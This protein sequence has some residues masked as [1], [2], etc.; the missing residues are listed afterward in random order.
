M[1][2]RKSKVDKALDGL[3]R[4][5][6]KAARRAAKRASK[7][8][9]KA[10]R[11]GARAIV[12]RMKV[13]P[14]RMLQDMRAAGWTPQQI[15]ARTGMSPR[16]QSN[17]LKGRSDGARYADALRQA[18]RSGRKRPPETIQPVTA[19]RIPG[20]GRVERTKRGTTITVR[21]DTNREW[22]AQAMKQAR[23]EIRVRYVDS[24]GKQ[25]KAETFSPRASERPQ[26][27]GK[28]RQRGKVTPATPA[29]IERRDNKKIMSPHEAWDNAIKGSRAKS[30]STYAKLKE[31]LKANGGDVEKAMRALGIKDK[32]TWKAWTDPDRTKRKEPGTAA[33]RKLDQQRN[34]PEFR[35]AALPRRRVERL[36]RSG[37]KVKLHGAIMPN[38]DPKYLRIRNA[39]VNLPP[40]AAERVLDAYADGGPE[41]AEQ[42]LREEMEQHY[43]DQGISFA[44]DKL[45]KFQ[46]SDLTEQDRLDMDYFENDD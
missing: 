45:D 13:K 1:T 30:V 17:V 42:V 18:R 20:A 46:I 19:A 37:M 32:R 14:D 5:A 21:P 23:G 31:L 10:I 36:K 43:T 6:K 35:R 15:Q 41:M 29:P 24:G 28:A 2:R 40:D 38:A 8:A 25:T 12:E 16:T 33:R 39:T 7:K 11:S 4:A 9:S 3:E 44:W 26:G 22:L 34:T 27:D